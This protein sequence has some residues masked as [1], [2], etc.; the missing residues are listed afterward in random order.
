MTMWM[1]RAVRDGS[2]FQPFIGRRLVAIGWVDVRD[3]RRFE[4]RDALVVELREEY[5]G[6]VR[7]VVRKR[8]STRLA[9]W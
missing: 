5:P 9:R 4:S 2:L 6:Q 3:L 8:W 7:E 1:V